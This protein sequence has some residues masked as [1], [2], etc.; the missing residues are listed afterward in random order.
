MKIRSIFKTL[1]P[2]GIKTRI[3]RPSYFDPF[4]ADKA[5]RGATQDSLRH[6]YQQVSMIS[7]MKEK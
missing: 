2:D 5:N 6:L 3:L 7:N 1:F 4:I